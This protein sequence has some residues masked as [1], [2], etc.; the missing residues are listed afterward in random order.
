MLE[1]EKAR[2]HTPIILDGTLR[3]SLDWTSA[4]QEAIDRLAKGDKLLWQMNL[5]LFTQLE[6]PLENQMQFQALQISLEHFRDSLWSEFK[7]DTEGLI[8][9][10][11]A[12]DFSLNF[13][14]NEDLIKNFQGWLQDR[15]QNISI[16]NAETG[17][18]V[19][20]FDELSPFPSSSPMLSSLVKLFCRDT[21]AGYL[22]MLVSHLPDALNLYILLRVDAPLLILQFFQ[23]SSQERFQRF[24]MVLEGDCRYSVDHHSTIGVC[25]PGADRVRPSELKALSKALE[26]MLA[27]KKSFR[28]IPEMFLI[29]Q[30]DGLDYLIYS[31]KALSAQGIRKL[32]GFCAAGGVPV[33][34][35]DISSL[36]NE[37]PFSEFFNGDHSFE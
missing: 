5:G 12:L 7:E 11:G 26:R 32:Q 6:K 31:S 24:H 25:L 10:S 28:I 13:P 2:F 34:V 29:N 8:L 33:A 14:W 16:F 22:N 1:E 21:I 20:S 30:W 27:V 18:S 37:I 15:F 3:A 23:C 35:D 4:R 36:P 9:Y 17:M 19:D